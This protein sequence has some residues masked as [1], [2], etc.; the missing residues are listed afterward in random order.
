MVDGATVNLN[1]VAQATAFQDAA[2]L[3]AN[4]AAATIAAKGTQSLKV[5]NPDGTES[6]PIDFTVT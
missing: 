6:S 4:I 5:V 1:D 2:T 3:T